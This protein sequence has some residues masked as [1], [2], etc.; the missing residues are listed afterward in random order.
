MKIS[1]KMQD[2]LNEQINAE[3]YSAYLYLSM[4]GYLESQDLSG[5]SHWM[6]KQAD[7][8]L[9]HGMK[10]FDYLIERGGTVA[11]KRIEEPP[12]SW[13]SPMAVFQESYEHEQKVT[14]LINKLYDSAKAEGDH[15][16]EISLQWFI[17]E[18]VE[19]EASVSAVLEKLRMSGGKGHALLLLDRELAQRK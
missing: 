18:Q 3:F 10:L 5:M 19:E 11:L 15:A 14:G 1:E 6:K 7:E 17:T 2:A 4:A 16:T 9:E 12:S 13:D 8:E